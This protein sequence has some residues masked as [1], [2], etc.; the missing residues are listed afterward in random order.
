MPLVWAIKP[1]TSL[2]L[3]GSNPTA[4]VL[5]LQGDN[6][7]VTGFVSDYI[8][9]SYYSSARV[10]VVPLRFGAGIKNKVLEALNKRVPLVTTTAG[11]QGMAELNEFVPIC[12]NP[13]D[14]ANAI[15]QFLENDQ[16]WSVAT[17]AGYSYV[18]D[19]FSMKSM[20]DFFESELQCFQ[21]QSVT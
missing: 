8:L 4:E 18:V 3:V 21:H 9:D 6:V 13:H 1:Q 11:I 12:D 15:I 2:S 14:F 17:H 19:K 7:E 5:A 16:A 10:A 20:Q